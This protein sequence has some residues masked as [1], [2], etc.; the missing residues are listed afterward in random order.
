MS[1]TR[2]ACCQQVQ[3]HWIRRLVLSVISVWIPHCYWSVWWK[4]YFWETNGWTQKPRLF[5]NACRE[6]VTR[7]RKNPSTCR[8]QLSPHPFH[9]HQHWWEVVKADPSAVC[10]L[11]D[12][13]T[14]AL[15]HCC[16]FPV[17]PFT[18]TLKVWFH[19]F[20]C[21]SGCSCLPFEVIGTWVRILVSS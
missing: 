21:H 4:W 14:A 2:F 8:D 5:S 18:T 17:L 16:R 10:F 15:Q 19:I 6:S 13:D 9:F 7:P 20:V 11:Q 3:I 1:K 12:C